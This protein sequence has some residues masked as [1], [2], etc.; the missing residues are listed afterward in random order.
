MRV[1]NHKSRI[2]DNVVKC[3]VDPDLQENDRCPGCFKIRPPH[4]YCSCLAVP[5]C[6][7][8]FRRYHKIDT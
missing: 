8:C 6:Q 7:S 2:V 1:L 5:L 4:D 3:L